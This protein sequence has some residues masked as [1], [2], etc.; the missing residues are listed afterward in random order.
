MKIVVNEIL[1][2]VVNE[3]LKLLSVKAASLKERKKRP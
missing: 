2:I 1:K 3:I